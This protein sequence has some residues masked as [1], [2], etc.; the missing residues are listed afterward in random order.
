[1]I[2][3]NIVRSIV[4]TAGITSAVVAG[5]ALKAE[6]QSR[7]LWLHTGETVTVEG[8]FFSGESIF[9]WCDGDCYD[10]DITLYDANGNFITQDIAPDANP[11]VYAP[12][13]GTFYITLGMPNCNHSSGCA[14]WVDSDQGF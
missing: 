10:L 13:E 2:T 7:E 8:Y 4:L 3:R 14:A 1:M 12:Y 11:V 9:G 6:A 5:T